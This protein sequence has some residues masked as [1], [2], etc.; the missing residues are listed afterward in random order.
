M[1]L[2]CGQ[3][4]KQDCV[5]Q[6]R[7]VCGDCRRRGLIFTLMSARQSLRAG[8]VD[9]WI[10]CPVATSRRTSP[11]RNQYGEVNTSRTDEMTDTA[12]VTSKNSSVYTTNFAQLFSDIHANDKECCTSDRAGWSQ[13]AHQTVGRHDGRSRGTSKRDSVARLLVG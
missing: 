3:S 5:L 7:T 12:A 11:V 8:S 4:K 2:S 1:K 6:R 10:A 9:L 13:R